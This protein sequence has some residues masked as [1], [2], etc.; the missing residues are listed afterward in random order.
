MTRSGWRLER[1]AC[2]DHAYRSALNRTC[3]H[4]MLSGKHGAPPDPLCVLI[5]DC[6]K[7]AFWPRA[8]L[9]VFLALLL[10]CVKAV[11][12]GTVLLIMLDGAC[13]CNPYPG[14]AKLQQLE[15]LL[16]ECYSLPPGQYQKQVSVALPQSCFQQYNLWRIGT[17]VCTI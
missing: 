10:Q 8:L 13:C 7:M 3:R 11:T 9:F 12:M 4:L 14:R 2:K 15:D 5:I 6:S 16:E 1:C 17:T